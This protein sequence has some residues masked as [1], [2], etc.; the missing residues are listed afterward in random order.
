MQ[1]YLK[2]ETGTILKNRI[3]LKLYDDYELIFTKK[4][5][6]LGYGGVFTSV[7]TL[8][9]YLQPHF[10]YQDMSKNRSIFP[11]DLLKTIIEDK[12]H[13]L[14]VLSRFGLSF[15][16]GDKTVGEACKEDNVHTGSFL[17]VS[18]FL[19]G[20][21]YS[22]FEISLPALMEY[23]RKAHTHFLDFLLPSIRRK[24]IEAINCTDINDV[25]FLLLKFYDD[26]V[27]EVHNH[28]NHENDE[29]F[30]YVS[31]LLNGITNDQ[32]RITD[33]S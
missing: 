28:M 18:N 21:N 19:Y 15:G 33:Y 7:V 6:I 26:Y 31:D 4:T 2:R 25:A 9:G 24:L 20:Q 13:L 23:L 30:R 14:G 11:C 12:P 29:V 10:N 1:N 8:H 27:Q 22:Q 17:A 32:F 5:L 3:N 16:F